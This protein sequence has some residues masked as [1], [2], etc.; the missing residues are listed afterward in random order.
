MSF[1]KT[2]RSIKSFLHPEVLHIFFCLKRRYIS[3]DKKRFKYIIKQKIGGSLP[4]SKAQ[5][6]SVRQN[7][8]RRERNRKEKEKIKKI[9]KQALKATT[10][11]EKLKIL[12]EGYKVI[13]KAASKN[14]I[15]KNNAARKKSKIAKILKVK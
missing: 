7:K 10:E 13:D 8:V 12:K 6:K 15:K 3:I 1:D 2:K 14:V 5:E 11:E 9:M 4:K